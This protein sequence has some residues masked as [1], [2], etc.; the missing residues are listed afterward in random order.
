MKAFY[1]PGPLE[2]NLGAP[3]PLFLCFSRLVILNYQ[4]VKVLICLKPPI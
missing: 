1:G 4:S 2:G 3:R